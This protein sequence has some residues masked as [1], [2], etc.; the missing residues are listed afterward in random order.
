MVLCRASRVRMGS[1]GF[2]KKGP[3]GIN[4]DVRDG[5]GKQGCAK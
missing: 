3:C 5:E 1:I 2:A 4:I